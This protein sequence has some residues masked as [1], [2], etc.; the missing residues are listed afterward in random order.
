MLLEVIG[1]YEAVITT[2]GSYVSYRDTDDPESVMRVV[3]VGGVWEVIDRRRDRVV[4]RAFDSLR[5]HTLPEAA[6]TGDVLSEWRPLA[7]EVD[8]L[9]GDGDEGLYLV[10]DDRVCIVSYDLHIALEVSRGDGAAPG[11]DGFLFRPPF[12]R[13]G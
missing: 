9:F 6:K 11:I 7:V 13:P 12:S 5:E 1:R 3:D 2:G 8:S 4:V 10:G